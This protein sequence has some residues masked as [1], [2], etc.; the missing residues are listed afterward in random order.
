MGLRS[1]L[2]E[3]SCISSD[4]VQRARHVWDRLS[5]C[6]FHVGGR[7]RGRLEKFQ[8]NDAI[9]KE[10]ISKIWLPTFKEYLKVVENTITAIEKFKE[11]KDLIPLEEIKA[12]L[13]KQYPRELEIRIYQVFKEI[14]EAGVLQK[15]FQD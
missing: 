7:E 8:T 11:R 10:K 4:S 1:P 6:C 15:L 3:V 5:C 14:D 9:L 12:E 13:L 2:S